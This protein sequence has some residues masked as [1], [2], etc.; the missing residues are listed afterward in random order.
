MNRTLWISFAALGFGGVALLPADGMAGDVKEAN[1]TCMSA[2]ALLIVSDGA[3]DDKPWRTIRNVIR[4]NKNWTIVPAPESNVTDRIAL[5]RWTIKHT[6]KGGPTT[7]YTVQCGHGG[8]CNEVARRFAERFPQGAPA[9]SVH[10]DVSNL[11][12]SPTSAPFERESTAP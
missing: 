10:C 5:T 7:A 8:T 3:D 12:E 11:L 6:Y 2:T 1:A 4:S 9:P